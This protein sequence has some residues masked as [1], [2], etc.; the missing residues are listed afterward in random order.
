ML[1]YFSAPTHSLSQ[2]SPPESSNQ[3]TSNPYVPSSVSN[4]PPTSSFDDFL[5]NLQFSHSDSNLILSPQNSQPSPQSIISLNQHTSPPSLSMRNTYPSCTQLLQHISLYKDNYMVSVIATGPML[6]RSH[7]IVT[8]SQN[9]IVKPR[10]YM[11]PLS[12][13]LLNP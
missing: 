1:S 6:S 7:K 5:P 12:I 8:R 9:N 13:L 11:L 10:K 2:S 3:H 4:S